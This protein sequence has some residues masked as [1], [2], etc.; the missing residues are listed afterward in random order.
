MGDRAMPDALKFSQG[1][2]LLNDYIT[3]GADADAR[4][5]DAFLVDAGAVVDPSWRYRVPTLHHLS[6]DW[7][8]DVPIPDSRNH[9]T[10]EIAGAPH[11]DR[12]AVDHSGPPGTAFAGPSAQL[13][14]QDEDARRDRLDD[15]GQKPDPGAAVCAPSSANLAL[16]STVFPRRF[17]L[18]AAT[19]ALREW[20][21]SG[22]RAPS[23]APLARGAGLPETPETKL[24]RDGD[25]NAIGGWRSPIIDVPVAA[26]NGEVCAIFGTT[27]P[28]PPTRLSSLYADHA[29]YIRRL[30]RATDRAVANRFLVCEDAVTIMRKALA[31]SIGGTEP[32]TVAPGCAVPKQAPKAG[33]FH[34]TG[35]MSGQQR[36]ATSA[37]SVLTTS[38]PSAL[39]ATGGCDGAMAGFAGIGAALA[40]WRIVQRRA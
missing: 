7:Q 13:S 23:A 5:A 32:F 3:N 19:A 33:G 8:L 4:L 20:G 29:S 34:P 14:R 40:L 21:R 26:Y 22:R 6:E 15:Y 25:G 36:P 38:A 31:S 37:A 10:W 35:P 24:A 18:N 16:T 30:K 28:L 17:S 39:P 2:G 1:T 9:V 11:A 27:T 12:W